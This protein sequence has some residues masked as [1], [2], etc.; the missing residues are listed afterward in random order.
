[1]GAGDHQA[2]ALFGILHI[3]H[4]YLDALALGKG[5][6]GDL[7]GLGQHGFAAAD[8]QGD[9]AADGIYPQHLGGNDIVL[10][11]LILLEQQALFGLPDTL[12]DGGFGRLGRDASELFR[13][14]GDFQHTSGGDA[15][16]VLGSILHADLG[17]WVLDL[18]H[19]ILAQRHIEAAGLGIDL[20]DAVFAVK[21]VLLDGLGDGGL[22]LFDHI[23][24]RDAF[25]LLQHLQGIKEVKFLLGF[26]LGSCSAHLLT[27]PLKSLY[28]RINAVSPRSTFISVSSSSSRVRVPSR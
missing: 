12:M 27:P 24:H 7:L 22:D 17:G 10:A 11:A 21:G 25:F 15:A 1:M 2:G 20:H 18:L 23:I 19:D 26:L 16:L 13:I 28:R 5:L 4:I 9:I 3:H 8:L 14:K 6:I